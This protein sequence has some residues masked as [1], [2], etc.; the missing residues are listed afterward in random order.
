MLTNA[1][2]F[3]NVWKTVFDTSRTVKKQ[4]NINAA[5]QPPKNV[6]VDFMHQS[7]KMVTGLNKTLQARWVK[8][9][10]DVSKA[11]ETTHDIITVLIN[12][13]IIII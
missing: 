8:V 9:P 10:F 6:M 1:V 7:G 12:E 3:K 13:L 5:E 2:Y 4:F 11:S